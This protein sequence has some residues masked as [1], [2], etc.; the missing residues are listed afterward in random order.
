MEDCRTA[1]GLFVARSIRGG[2]G[3]FTAT[4]RRKGELL[5]ISYSWELLPSDLSLIDLSSI[6]GYWFYHPKN[7]GWGLMPIGLAALVNCSIMPNAEIVWVEA[8]IGC[9]GYLRAIE[10]IPEAQEILIDYG[11]GLEDGWIP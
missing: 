10:D 5:C 2:R 7:N 11:I 9:L 3:V 8:E 6:E 4:P 1:I